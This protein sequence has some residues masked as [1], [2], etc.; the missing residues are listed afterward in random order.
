MPSWIRRRQSLR[1]EWLDLLVVS[2]AR[3]FAQD[4]KAP[5][6]VDNGAGNT[7]HQHR[8]G[9]PTISRGPSAQ[10]SDPDTMCVDSVPPVQTMITLSSSSIA[11]ITW[12]HLP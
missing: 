8:G 5:W 11:T 3:R 2:Q 7:I 1:A 10:L 12:T 9:I 6:D 4:R